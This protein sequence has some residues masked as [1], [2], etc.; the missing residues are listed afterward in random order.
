[1][2]VTQ[3]DPQGFGHPHRELIGSRALDEIKLPGSQGVLVTA[4]N[5]GTT[6]AFRPAPA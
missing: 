3:Y 4:R 6:P 1:M 5:V 2:Q